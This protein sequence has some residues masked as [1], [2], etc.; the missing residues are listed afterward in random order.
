MI[1]LPPKNVNKPMKSIDAD[2]MF[3]K[4]YFSIPIAHI[5]VFVLLLLYIYIMN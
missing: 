3:R 1:I 2:A 5:C 4:Y